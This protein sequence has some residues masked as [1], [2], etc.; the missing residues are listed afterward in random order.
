MRVHR[1]W[2]DHKIF[3]TILH[4]PRLRNQIVHHFLKLSSWA[5]ETERHHTKPALPVFTDR[6]PHIFAWLM[7]LICQ[8]PWERF[9]V[10][11]TVLPFTSSNISSVSG[12]G[13]LSRFHHSVRLT[14]FCAESCAFVLFCDQHYAWCPK[15]FHRSDDA[16]IWHTCNSLLHDVIELCMQSFQLSEHRSSRQ[17]LEYL[18]GPTLWWSN[19]IKRIR[20]NISVAMEYVHYLC[21]TKKFREADSTFLDKKIYRKRLIIS[22]QRETWFRVKLS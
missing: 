20:N 14:V 12:S 7:L 15:R 21:G 4:I 5:L 3:K 1:C 17:K 8:Y 16:C 2:I 18:W 9:S 10:G 22:V 6:S 13:H 11:N 19:I